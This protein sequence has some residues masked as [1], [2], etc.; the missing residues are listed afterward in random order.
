MFIAKFKSLFIPKSAEHQGM[1]QQIFP[2]QILL[3]IVTDFFTYIRKRTTSILYFYVSTC[4]SRHLCW[5][6]SWQNFSNVSVKASNCHAG[7]P[8]PLLERF[9]V[10]TGVCDDHQ[11]SPPPKSTWVWTGSAPRRVQ[12]AAARCSTPPRCCSPRT[13]GDRQVEFEEPQGEENGESDWK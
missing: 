12:S 10:V 2:R 8:Q 3:V 4:A 7:E 9:Q 1:F 5:F 6:A 11:S 13:S